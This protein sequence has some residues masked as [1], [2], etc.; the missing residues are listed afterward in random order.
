MIAM[1]FYSDYDSDNNNA[2]NDNTDDDNVTDN[3]DT[4]HN[5]IN[6]VVI[7]RQSYR[8]AIVHVTRN[9]GQSPT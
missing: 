4:N 2:D 8:S 3:N 5:I 6:S 9:M 7:I 1:I